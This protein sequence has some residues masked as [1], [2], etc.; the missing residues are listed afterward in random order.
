MANNNEKTTKSGMGLDDL[1]FSG[2]DTFTGWLW[3]TVG[4]DV[5]SP[6]ILEL[7]E[8]TA[9]LQ[10]E[11]ETLPQGART[12]AEGQKRIADIEK[13]ITENS[14]EIRRIRKE[15]TKKSRKLR[16]NWNFR[17]W[18]DSNFWLTGETRILPITPRRLL[19]T[20]PS[21]RGLN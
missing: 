16:K 19:M 10:L 21:G 1:L 20:Q 18:S 6:E 7:Q 13:L 11:M 3:R 9:A 8:Q 17:R 5:T 4:G 2:V 12:L 15:I 14:A